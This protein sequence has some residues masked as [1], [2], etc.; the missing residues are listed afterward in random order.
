MMGRPQDRPE[1]TATLEGEVGGPPEKVRFARVRLR[2]QGEEWLAAPT[3]GR[4]S[5]LLATV[6]RANGLAVVP[7]G[8]PELLAGD[9]CPV[10]VFR[11]PDEP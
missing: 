6:S 4:R 11:D 8:T 5:N 9:R 2:R 1:V 7:A 3:G 10:I